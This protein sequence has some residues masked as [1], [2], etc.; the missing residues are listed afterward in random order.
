M[1]KAILKSY[2]VN[3]KAILNATAILSLSLMLNLSQEKEKK[4]GEWSFLK[5]FPTVV[6][7]SKHCIHI[8]PDPSKTTTAEV[9]QRRAFYIWCNVHN[10]DDTCKR[11]T[12]WRLTRTARTPDSRLQATATAKHNFYFS[13]LSHT[14]TKTTE[15]ISTSSNTCSTSSNHLAPRPSPRLASTSFHS[16]SFAYT[17]ST[18]VYRIVST[19]NTDT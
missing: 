16:P 2:S 8:W 1:L 10:I 17:R 6:I 15:R 19:H 13:N 11:Q 9:E 4:N 5:L 14:L 18:T 3:A 7:T 12:G